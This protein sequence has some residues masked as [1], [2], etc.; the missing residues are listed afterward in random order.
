MSLMDD[1][2][3]GCPSCLIGQIVIEERWWQ[4]VMP[5]QWIGNHPKRLTEEDGTEVTPHMTH[6][7]RSTLNTGLAKY[8]GCNIRLRA[9][10]VYRFR[11]LTRRPEE[12]G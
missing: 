7:R 8:W 4:M 5:S 12:K 6:G 3:N 1:T 2:C 9:V 11:W 10:R